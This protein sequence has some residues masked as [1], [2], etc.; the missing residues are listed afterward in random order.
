MLAIL[1]FHR[2]EVSKFLRLLEEGSA[3]QIDAYLLEF[4]IGK[5]RAADFCQ[6]LSIMFFQLLLEV[7]EQIRF[8]LCAV[9][10]LN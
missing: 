4:L 5:C 8:F 10:S 9:I 2:K 7:A 6:R 1:G 3:F